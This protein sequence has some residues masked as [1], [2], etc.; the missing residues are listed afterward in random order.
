MNRKIGISLLLIFMVLLHGCDENNTSVVKSKPESGMEKWIGA[1]EMESI[2]YDDDELKELTRDLPLPAGVLEMNV[3]GVHID[4]M[5]VFASNSTYFWH[6][7]LDF[8]FSLLWNDGTRFKLQV[9][10]RLEMSGTYVVDGDEYVLVSEDIRLFVVDGEWLEPI[11]E[12]MDA[13]ERQLFS[14]AMFKA[15]GGE[16]YFSNYI[17]TGNWA[18]KMG[19]LVLK[20][21]D[22][23]TLVLN[24][25]KT[26]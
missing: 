7:N 11:R 3:E 25:K 4:N 9:V 22:G 8:V 15:L 1:W 10:P 19:K 18:Y 16:N 23:D 26:N 17:G 12:E 21:S 5:M 14:E 2:F 20:K 6:S 13:D 24:K